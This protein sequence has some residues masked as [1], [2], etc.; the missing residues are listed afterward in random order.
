LGRGPTR[1][2]GQDAA[3]PDGGHDEDAG[4]GD[5]DGDGDDDD[6]DDAPE[7]C[8]RSDSC[9]KG[10]PFCHPT[11]LL[12]LECLSDRDCDDGEHCHD[13]DCDDR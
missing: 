2:A 11:L 13:G 5:G 6:D 9:P 7:P 3:A 4:D 8:L 12:C 1:D 10:E